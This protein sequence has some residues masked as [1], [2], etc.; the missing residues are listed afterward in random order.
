VEETG[1][2]LPMVV[3]VEARGLPSLAAALGA[4]SAVEAGAGL[5]LDAT[6][7]HLGSRRAWAALESDRR[8]LQQP[9]AGLQQGLHGMLLEQL[10]GAQQ[11]EPWPL[12]D[13]HRRQRARM[14][15]GESFGALA[16]GAGALRASGQP[17]RPERP[18]PTPGA[19]RPLS[20]QL[21]G[22]S[23]LQCDGADALREP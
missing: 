4:G 17:N 10:R 9:Q 7:V 20:A 16:S 3:L 2:A 5:E 23:R 22:Q 1:R 8:G 12:R 13:L 19:Q 15:A 6:R 21:L 11:Q 14:C 18:L